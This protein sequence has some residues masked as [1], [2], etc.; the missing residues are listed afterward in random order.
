MPVSV[1]NKVQAMVILISNQLDRLPL[2]SIKFQPQFLH[3]L[4][5]PVS[6]LCLTT[7]EGQ[8][9]GHSIGPHLAQTTV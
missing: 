3:P 7:T 8:Q 4:M 2:S 6:L 1:T 5:D 9:S